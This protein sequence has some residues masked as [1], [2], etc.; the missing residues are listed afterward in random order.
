MR[1]LA[2]FAGAGGGILG[3]ILLG[4]RPVC[5]VEIDPYCRSVLLARQR[6]GF[7][8]R[9]P[10]W[11]DIRTFDGRPWNGSIDV[12]SGGFP[13][14]DISP[15]GSRAGIG[16][17]KSGLWVEMARIIREV[18]PQHVFV[19]NSADITARGLGRVLG[20]LAEMGFDARWGVLGACA[21]GAPHMRYRMWIVANAIDVGR[22]QRYPT[23][24]GGQSRRAP[25]DDR[26]VADASFVGGAPGRDAQRGDEP[27]QP[28][29]VGTDAGCGNAPNT[30]DSGERGLVEHAQV[31]SSPATE[32]S[33][34]EDSA[35]SDRASLWEQPRRGC[36]ESGQGTAEPQVDDWWPVD[37]LQGVDDGMAHRVDRVAA[38]GNGQVPGVAALAWETL[39]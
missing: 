23:A 36:R 22:R 11:D 14:Q 13:C 34:G 35:N 8:P 28:L 30:D 17:E 24:R 1:E 6:D 19:E 9:F 37:L 29:S 27:Q 33:V 4:W 26:D 16:G 2:L 31:A 21:V 7:L 20:D 32:G 5:A 18:R 39:R 15:A 12:V 38:T 25:A 3:G 10:I